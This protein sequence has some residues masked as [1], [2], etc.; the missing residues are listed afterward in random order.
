MKLKADFHLHTSEDPYDSNIS[1]TARAL[2]DTAAARGFDV[3]AI[4]NH[5]TITRGD[6]LKDYAFKRGI[7]LIPGIEL[8]VQG[9]HIVLL[10]FSDSEVGRIKTVDDIKRLKGRNRLV[11]APHP[12]FPCSHSLKNRLEENLEVFD[13]LEL[14]S[15]YF[16]WA[17]FN[18]KA[19][20]TAGRSGLP[21]IGSSDTHY[22]SQLGSTYSLI[23]AEKDVQSVIQAVKEG[24][25][26]VVTHPL[27]FNL[28][29][30][31]MALHF[32]PFIPKIWYKGLHRCSST[33]KRFR[34]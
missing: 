29:N 26:E 27:A 34:L 10:N 9:R 12:F 22:L 24:R 16:S 28:K 13:A 6:S 11:I 33:M 31:K 21:L 5:N 32:T 1:Y 3:L 20:R 19:R 7:L 15:L 8:T 2:I 23:E 4:T 17:D 14:T 25:F 18:G 30:I